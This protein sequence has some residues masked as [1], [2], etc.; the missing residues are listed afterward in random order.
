MGQAKAENYMEEVLRRSRQGHEG[1]GQAKAGHYMEEMLIK[2]G[3]EGVGQAKAGHYMEE[4]LIKQERE[5]VG[6]K[7]TWRRCSSSRDVRAW[8]RPRQET[9]LT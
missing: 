4:M 8:G 9:E 7:T 5:G 3:R 6:Q 1:V 2:Q